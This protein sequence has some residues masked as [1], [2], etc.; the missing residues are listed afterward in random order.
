MRH[1][2]F[3][4]GVG[5]AGNGTVNG[6]QA[7]GR[8]GHGGIKAAGV[9]DFQAVFGPGVQPGITHLEG[10]AIQCVRLILPG[11]AAGGSGHVFVLHV[12]PG[13]F[14]PGGEHSPGV[15]LPRNILDKVRL[16]FRIAQVVI[17][18]AEARVFPVE[19]RLELAEPI[20]LV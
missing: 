13:K 16:A 2:K 8:A 14:L 4:R 10:L 9:H 12:V 17:E 3:Q 19:E 5:G 6:I 1:V 11:E 15:L 18:A 7:V 20:A